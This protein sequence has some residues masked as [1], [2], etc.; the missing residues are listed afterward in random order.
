MARTL[1][2]KKKLINF[3]IH[4]HTNLASVS[5]KVKNIKIGVVRQ[6]IGLFVALVKVSTERI[7]EISM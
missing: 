7:K 6:L 2:L 1:S 5:A 4:M 3:I